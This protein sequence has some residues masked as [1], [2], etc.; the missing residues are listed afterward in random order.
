MPVELGVVDV[1]ILGS[2]FD[3]QVT[4][5]ELGHILVLPSIVC[6]EANGIFCKLVASG[7]SNCYEDCRN[8]S[9]HM[10]RAIVVLLQNW[11]MT[12][13]QCLTDS[14]GSDIS[15]RS[16]PG[17]RRV[18][19]FVR[20]FFSA[21]PSMLHVSKAHADVKAGEVDA[22][23]CASGG[24]T[25]HRLSSVKDYQ[26]GLQM[27]KYVWRT[28]FRTLVLDL[29]VLF[30]LLESRRVRTLPQEGQE[31][32]VAVNCRPADLDIA[33]KLIL[34][35]VLCRLRKSEAWEFIAHVLQRCADFGVEVCWREKQLR[36][37]ALTGTALQEM[38]K[39]NE[40][41]D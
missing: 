28:E 32:M 6:K 18:D 14:V 4:I 24:A 1:F 36:V 33:I 20:K 35:N 27:Q 21:W 12:T 5:G 30:Q 34:G 26:R 8:M 37:D 29:D 10:E 7:G 17:M 31:S 38:A 19:G 3:E 15:L 2:N 13:H 23:L 11:D 16:F 22:T 41:C 40:K 9:L 25:V 39:E